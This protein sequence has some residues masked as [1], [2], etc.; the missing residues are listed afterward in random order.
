MSQF[1]QYGQPVG[2]ALP[3]W[4]PV[5][6]PAIAPLTGRF[7]TLEPLQAGH[8]APLLSAFSQAE[9][10]RDWT[11]LGADQPRS[12]PEMA[13]WVGDKMADVG[14]VSYAVVNHASQ[15]AV[16][17]VCF[18]NIDQ[19]N[20]AL[21]IGHVT[22][23]PLMQRNVLGSEAIYLLLSQA[24]ALGYRRVAWRCDST[25]HASR[26][27]AERLGFSFEGRFRQ[28]MTR[29]QRNRDTDWLS[30]IDSEWPAIQQAMTRWLG[31]ENMDSGGQQI[32]PL[33]HFLKLN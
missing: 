5:A 20:G 18:A 14:L 25:N 24:F 16:G 17:L 19:Q 13:R 33:H 21:E 7:C 15:Q 22:W 4:Q 2:F 23:S 28:A 12:L 31:E 26:R 1:N 30:I 11:W 9:D 3:H 29:K 6:R 27:A 10:D 32:Q 8:C